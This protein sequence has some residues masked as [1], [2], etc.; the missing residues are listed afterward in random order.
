VQRPF[1]KRLARAIVFA[2]LCRTVLNELLRL[3]LVAFGAGVGVCA[4]V[5]IL[6][7]LEGKI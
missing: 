2:P 4:C 7:V 3:G 6:D 5:Q 1:L